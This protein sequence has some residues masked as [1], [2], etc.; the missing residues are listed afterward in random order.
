M[1]YPWGRRVN[2]IFLDIYFNKSIKTAVPDNRRRPEALVLTK[3]S[4]GSRFEVGDKSIFS[5]SS[6]R[7]RVFLA[8]CL[9]FSK[10]LRPLL[11]LLALEISGAGSIFWTICG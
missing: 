7:F 4:E 11:A 1:S 2:L 5:V 9:L 10:L 6:D 3:L 8:A